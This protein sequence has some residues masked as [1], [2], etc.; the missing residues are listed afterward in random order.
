MKLAMVGIIVK[1]MEKAIEFYKYLGLEIDKKYGDDYVELK[2]STIRISLNTMSM[3]ENVYGFVPDINGERI[4]LA[5][6]LDSKKELDDL[7]KKIETKGYDILKSPWLAPWGQYYS[8]VKDI[9]G[10]IL[11][12]FVNE[13]DL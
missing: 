11:S 8:L 6:E 2:N 5:F 7:Y 4:E 1:D 10:N 3:I 12:L 13:E 9:D